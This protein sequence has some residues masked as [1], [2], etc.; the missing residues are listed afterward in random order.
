MQVLVCLLITLSQR[1]IYELLINNASNVGMKM[2]S[3]RCLL[4][5]KRRRSVHSR[6]ESFDNSTRFR[7]DGG[8]NGKSFEKEDKFQLKY[9]INASPGVLKVFRLID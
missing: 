5:Q 7:T 4:N 2:R 3:R 1:N 9:I 8:G 6:N